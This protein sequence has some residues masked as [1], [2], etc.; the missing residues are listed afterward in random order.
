M[1]DV[2]DGGGDGGLSCEWRVHDYTETFNLEVSFIQ[3]FE[4]ATIVKIVIKWY[5]EMGV[6]DGGD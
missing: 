3:G 1:G 6:S 4:Q 2:F 5:G